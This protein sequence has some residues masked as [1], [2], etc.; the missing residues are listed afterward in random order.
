MNLF[1]VG[2]ETN[3]LTSTPIHQDN[4]MHPNGKKEL[5]FLLKKNNEKEWLIKEFLLL[6]PPEK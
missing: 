1:S 6:L 3:F 2:I 4:E 5:I